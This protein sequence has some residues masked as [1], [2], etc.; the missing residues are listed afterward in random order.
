MGLPDYSKCEKWIANTVITICR[1]ASSVVSEDPEWYSC[2][3]LWVKGEKYLK[4][5]LD[6]NLP[7]VE[8]YSWS[9]ALCRQW[10]WLWPKQFNFNFFTTIIVIDINI[11]SSYVNFDWLLVT[12][13]SINTDP[14]SYIVKHLQGQCLVRKH[15][16]GTVGCAGV[17]HEREGG[18]DCLMIIMIIMI[19]IIIMIIKPARARGPERPARWER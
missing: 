3:K 8:R 9:W 13:S 6:N 4:S 12:N 7:V 1:E 14:K 5:I 17:G 2:T 10:F 18:E 11:S 16:V 15:G 19:I